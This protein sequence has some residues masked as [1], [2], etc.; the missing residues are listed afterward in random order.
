M[1]FHW[2]CAPQEG[3]GILNSAGLLVL[4]HHTRIASNHAKKGSQVSNPV[5]AA[6]YELPTPPGTYLPNDYVCKENACQQP[7]CG[8]ICNFTRFP[9]VHMANLS[10]MIDDPIPFHCPRGR[11]CDGNGTYPCDA[12]LLGDGTNFSDARCGGEC[13]LG[14]YCPPASVA[15]VPCSAGTYGDRTGLAAQHECLDCPVGSWCAGGIRFACP[16]G[17]YNPEPRQG[18]LGAC[19]PCK[20]GSR[21]TTDGEGSTS[22]HDCVCDPFTMLNLS[23]TEESFCIDPPA[24]FAVEDELG[25]TTLTAQIKPGYWRPSKFATTAHPCPLR[26]TC[27]GGQSSANFSRNDTS[28]C[29]DGFMGPYCTDCVEAFH[30]V[31][32]SST[33]TRCRSCKAAHHFFGYVLLICIGAIA[34]I[35]IGFVLRAC[36]RSQRIAVTPSLLQPLQLQ[37]PAT[38]T[39][40]GPPPAPGTRRVCARIRNAWQRLGS[41]VGDGVHDLAAACRQL[42][43]LPLVLR[44]RAASV[45]TALPNKLK[46]CLSVT[47]IVAQMGDVYQIVYPPSYQSLSDNLFAPLRGQLFGWIPGLRL[48]CFGIERLEHVLVLYALLPVAIITLAFAI[49]WC[50]GRSLLPA[51]PFVL[52]FTYVVFPIISSKGFQALAECDTF[53]YIDGS[54]LSLLPSDWHVECPIDGGLVAVAWLAVL[55]YGAGVPL[56]YAALLWRCRD[57]IV[58]GKPDALSRALAF[59]HSSL[60]PSALWWPLVEAARALILTGFLAL[61]MPGSITQLLFGLMA[62]IS[63]LVLQ[64]WCAPYQQSSSNF[65]AMVASAGLALHFVTSLGVQFNSQTGGTYVKGV[66]LSIGLYVAASA[67][68]VF[69]LMSFLGSR[70]LRIDSSSLRMAL[71]DLAGD[72]PQLSVRDVI[73]ALNEPLLTEDE[74]G[75]LRSVSLRAAQNASATSDRYTA[76]AANLLLSEPEAA[77]RGV[78]S[79]V[80]IPYL[81]LL[82]RMGQG[83]Q[84]IIDECDA[85]GTDDDKHWLDYVLRQPAA[86][87]EGLHEEG[88]AGQLLSYFVN[89]PNAIVAGLEEAHVVALRWYTSPAYESLNRP[90]RDRTRMEAHPFAVTIAFIND[91][92]KRLRA[93]ARPESGPSTALRLWRGMRNV[94]APDELRRT[95]G[96]EL[97]M[98]STTTDLETAVRFST[99][100][101]AFLV[102]ITP[103]SFMQRGADTVWLSCFPSE[104]EILY[105][106]CTYL[107]PTGRV[108]AIELSSELRCTVVEMTPHHGS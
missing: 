11:W 25:T 64:I 60:N 104:R 92:I 2:S 27:A 97:A 93:I 61:L 108:Q 3:G 26:G 31:S 102:L 91:G 65:L 14:A 73:R 8:Q 58:N 90:L 30:Y 9:D 72:G 12:G 83:V 76:D 34:A 87:H 32:I 52:R 94:Q 41:A 35:V 95:G 105:P 82:T 63:F 70:S 80:G 100:R 69:T 107:R 79:V 84:A 46:I 68:F 81:E 56:A 85:H 33:S 86:H 23:A 44:L 67:V 13:P 5:A 43:T 62:A 24:G 6:L 28:L 18:N 78:A 29:H 10:L 4:S 88:R 77:A 50:R 15:Q 19:V 20:I 89:H 75:T 37:Q 71:H 74:V 55:L 47:L 101:T 48:S 21:T 38:A 39:A 57:A 59:L 54:K 66:L 42:S 53:E 22:I 36:C 98:L 1:H 17:T 106:P 51:L 40:P 7:P 96:T 45:A 16:N 49:S 99:S 103:R